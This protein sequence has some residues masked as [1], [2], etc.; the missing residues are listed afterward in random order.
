MSATQECHGVTNGS[1]GPEPIMHSGAVR[2]MEY[3]QEM[4][5]TVMI[6]RGTTR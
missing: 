5:Y 2:A 3:V 6:A 4:N 1:G